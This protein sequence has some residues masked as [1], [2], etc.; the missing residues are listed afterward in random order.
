M[1]S[2]S[3][4]PRGTLLDNIGMFSH[5]VSIY[6]VFL[7]LRRKSLQNTASTRAVG[8]AYATLQKNQKDTP[9]SF[10]VI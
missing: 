1:L 7:R 8:G 9:Y 5:D 6:A 10:A 2:P 3:I 4:A